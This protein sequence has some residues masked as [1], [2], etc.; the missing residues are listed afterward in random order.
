MQVKQEHI[1]DMSDEIKEAVRHFINKFVC[2]HG[3]F[4]LEEHRWMAET[5]VEDYL[6]EDIQKRFKLDSEDFIIEENVDLY[7]SHGKRGVFVENETEHLSEH[8][9]NE[10]IH[11]DITYYEVDM[12]SL[13]EISQMGDNNKKNRDRL[14]EMGYAKED[15]FSQREK[16]TEKDKALNAFIKGYTIFTAGRCFWADYELSKEASYSTNKE[17][18]NEKAIKIIRKTCEINNCPTLVDQMLSD[19]EE[20]LKKKEIVFYSYKKENEIVPCYIKRLDKFEKP[21]RDKIEGALGLRQGDLDENRITAW[22]VDEDFI[23]WN[24]YVNR[25]GSA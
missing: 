14:I 4:Y 24:V 25:K 2:T 23:R 17:T 12:A 13:I 1:E 11:L 8:T 3:N 7:V 16:I 10:I 9:G 21:V 22:F 6:D 19:V 20:L 18:A 5:D 15:D